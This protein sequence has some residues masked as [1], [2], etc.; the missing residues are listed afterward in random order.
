M[1]QYRI[2]TGSLTGRHRACID[3]HIRDQ[4]AKK[5]QRSLPDILA[6]RIGRREL[7]ADVDRAALQALAQRYL[8][9][10][11][12]DLTGQLVDSLQQAVA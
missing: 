4:I 9:D 1:V 12:V 7:P 3:R 6:E 10:A 8:A 11:E 5:R 2:R